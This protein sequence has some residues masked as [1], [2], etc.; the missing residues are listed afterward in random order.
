MSQQNKNHCAVASPTNHPAQETT[1][2]KANVFE[3]WL[4]SGIFFKEPQVYQAGRVKFARHHVNHGNPRLV[5]NACS[6][7][8][9]PYKWMACRKS[10]LRN[11]L[12]YRQGENLPL[13]EIIENGVVACCSHCLAFTGHGTVTTTNFSVMLQRH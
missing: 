11:W 1:L 13:F 2:E 4:F 12:A 3:C 6:H 9:Q 8:S 7:R 5:H 10:K